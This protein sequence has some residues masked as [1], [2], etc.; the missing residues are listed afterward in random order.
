MLD[1]TVAA[2]RAALAGEHD[3]VPVAAMAKM[4][5]AL[6]ATHRIAVG[7]MPI[8]ERAVPL[9]DPADRSAAEARVRRDLSS[10]ADAV[11]VKPGMLA[12]DLV[13][14]LRAAVDRPIVAYHTADEHAIFAAE[15]DADGAAAE[16]EML[17]ASRRAGADLIVSYGALGPSI[18]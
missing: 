18:H 3:A 13:A 5:S 7:A 15:T 17:A 14:S 1:G 2:I 9:L 4:E 10:G 6:Y 16:R 12:L 8:S 11:V